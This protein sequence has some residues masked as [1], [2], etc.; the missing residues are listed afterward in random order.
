MD[1]VYS[2]NRAVSLDA[3]KS[4]LN[5]SGLADRRPIDND[6]CLQNMLIHSNLMVTAWKQVGNTDDLIGIARCVTDF[7]YCCYLSD[8]AIH[9]DYQN[10][11]I[12]QSLQT[13]VMDELADTCKVILLAAPS[14][15]AYYEQLAGKGLAYQPHSRCWVLDKNG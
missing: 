2:S 9:R 8:L 6:E 4:I 5:S 15:H 11:G 1:V 13:F 7:H 3:F 12:G 10:M 14:A